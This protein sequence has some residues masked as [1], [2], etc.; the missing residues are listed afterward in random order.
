MPTVAILADIHSNFP[1]LEAVLRD[2]EQCGAERI[3]FLG[4]IVGYGGSPAECVN[5]VRKMGG[6]CVM[7]NHDVEIDK[8]RKRGCTFRDADWK[9]CE[10]QA[11]LAHSARCLDADQAQWLSALPFRMK[12]PGAI[13]AHG[14][15]DEPEAFNYIK[16]VKSASPTLEILRKEKSKVGFF[17]HT[18]EQGIFVEDAAGLEW[19]DET[20][21]KVPVGWACAVTVGAVGRPRDPERRAAWVLWDPGSGVVDFR[22]TDYN[23]LQA[24]HDI[25][26]AKLPIASALALLTA[27]EVVELP[28]TEDESGSH[29]S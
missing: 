15:L 2:V 18:H 13:A 20:R 5:L 10:Y 26:L 1:A 6:A 21:V 4:D 3:V 16:D 7:G 23:R 8:V 19:L 24:A 11:G 12:L 9:C 22:K 14:S 25:M 17:G 28:M 27:A 29:L